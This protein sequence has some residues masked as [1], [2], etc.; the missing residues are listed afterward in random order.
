M[1]KT[2]KTKNNLP[3]KF[4]LHAAVRCQNVS[5]LKNL[6]D[7]GMDVNE[8]D[9]AGWVPA[10]YAARD[11]LG[12][13]LALLIQAQTELNAQ[14]PDGSTALML[15]CQD[16]GVECVELFLKAGADVDAKN[17]KGWT[18]AMVAARHGRIVCLA[19]LIRAGCDVDGRDAFGWTA[20]MHAANSCHRK[21]LALLIEAGSNLS[22]QTHSQE[23]A[24]SIAQLRADQ[25]SV[26]M[27]HAALEAQSLKSC[28][29]S[30][31]HNE[32]SQKTGPLRI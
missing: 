11:G 26:D 30:K 4:P 9:E 17:N 23:T 10:L 25:G 19:L 29:A 24:L 31:L 8:R 16:N 5:Q 1:K 7:Q 3:V 14:N 32:T 18:P 13:G 28:C 20:L 27:L 6:L 15:A 21:G 22:L 2:I 12:D